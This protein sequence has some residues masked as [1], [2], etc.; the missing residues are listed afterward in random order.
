MAKDKPKDEEKKP[1]PVQSGKPLPL[2]P[3]RFTR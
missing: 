3:T 2:D 1:R